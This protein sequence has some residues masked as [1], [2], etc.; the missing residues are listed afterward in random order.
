MGIAKMGTLICI[1]SN[2]HGI[3]ILNHLHQEKIK[4]AVANQKNN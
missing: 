4:K 2:D 1:S 3:S